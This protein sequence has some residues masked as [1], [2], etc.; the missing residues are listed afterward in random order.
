MHTS[1]PTKKQHYIPRMIL[2]HFVYFRIP[3]RKPLIYQYDKVSHTER[4]VDIYDVCR[5]NNLYELRDENNNIV[6]AE[7]NLIEKGFSVLE[8]YWDKAIRKVI[9]KSDLDETD[10]NWLCLLIV[11]QLLRTP[12]IMKF[13]SDW[14]YEVSDVIDKPL[15]RYVAD[16]YSKLATFV[17]G[18]VKPETNWILDMVLQFVLEDKFLVVYESDKPFIL[19]GNRPVLCTHFCEESNNCTWFLPIADN[20]CLVL[21]DNEMNRYVHINDAMVDY[22]NSE[23]YANDGRY[24]YSSTSIVHNDIL[25]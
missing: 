3:M 21:V 12:E 16:R 22:I 4:L 25:V 1:R 15:E 17:W 6:E 5:K 24:I 20:Y 8:S 10:E 14:L 23:I 18:E 13:T 19:N 7:R 9:N 2:K 11:L